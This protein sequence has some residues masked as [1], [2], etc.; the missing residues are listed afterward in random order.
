M[1]VG[2]FAFA[3]N[4]HKQA[5]VGVCVRGVCVGDVLMVGG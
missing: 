1:L 2:E 3:Q 5:D 4:S